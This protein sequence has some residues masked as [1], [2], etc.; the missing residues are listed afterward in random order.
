MYTLYKSRVLTD[1]DN[2]YVVRQVH[3]DYVVERR[4]TEYLFVVRHY[5]VVPRHVRRAK[6]QTIDIGKPCQLPFSRE[7][8]PHPVTDESMSTTD[9]RKNTVHTRTSQDPQR[10]WNRLACQLRETPTTRDRRI[11]VDHGHWR[12]YWT[13]TSQDLQ[14]CKVDDFAE[15]W[16]SRDHKENRGWYYTVNRRKTIEVDLE[17]PSTLSSKPKQG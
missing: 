15:S 8:F 11:D 4:E 2:E 9:I 3:C 13:R 16:N 6:A 5:R 10:G 1:L 7:K 14:I 17:A 12:E